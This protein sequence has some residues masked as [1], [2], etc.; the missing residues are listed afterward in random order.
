M[1]LSAIIPARNEA[2]AL[3][4]V[5]RALRAEVDEIIVA[6]GG[7]SDD[8]V[9]IATAWG[10]RVVT[11]ARGRGPQLDAGAQAATGERLWF[12]HADTVVAAGAGAALRAATTRWGCCSVRIDGRH[13]LYR[14]TERM[15][16][17]RARLTGSCTGD[18]GIWLDRAFYTELGGFAPIPLLE[19]LELSDRARAAAPW[20]VVC[21]PVHTSAR[22]WEE[23]GVVRTMM[24][25]WL[26]RA[27]FRLGQDPHMLVRWYQRES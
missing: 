12:L 8:T 23:N 22:R 9:G 2:T 4:A 6:D 19:D 10:A 1:R 27:G 24:R 5:L 25:M 20:T 15:M 26:V 3:P 13:P 14:S 7:S 17:L 21:P 18:M 16:A 11:G